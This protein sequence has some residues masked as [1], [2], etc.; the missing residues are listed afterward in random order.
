MIGKLPWH[1]IIPLLLAEKT[2]KRIFDIKIKTKCS[3]KNEEQPTLI[4]TYK[5]LEN[6]SYNSNKILA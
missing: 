2:V 5:L 6:C 1:E 3:I 4:S